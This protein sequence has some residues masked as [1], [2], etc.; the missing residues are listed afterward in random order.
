MGKGYGRFKREI[1]RAHEGK[2]TLIII[3]EGTLTEVAK[4]YSHS[5]IK[6]V[7][8]VYKLF[9]LWIRYGVQTVFCKDRREMSG[10]IMNFYIACG[11]EYV[12]R[13]K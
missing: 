12:R 9:T 2:S 6:G 11:K 13:K 10:Y 1:Q 4:G 3:V 7:S 8:M 5:Q